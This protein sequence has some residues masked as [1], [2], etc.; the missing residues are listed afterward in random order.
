MVEP[1]DPIVDVF[2]AD[3]AVAVTQLLYFVVAFLAIWLAGRIVVVPLLSRAMSRRDLDRHAKVPLLKVTRISI[4]FVGIAVAFGFADYGNFLTSL[5][6]IAAAATLAIGFAMQDVIQN[7][8][9]GVFIFTD[10]PFRIGD[11]IEWGD[12]SGVVEDISLRVTRVRT[13][14][15]ELLTVPNSQLTDGVIKN[16]VAKDQLR[17]KFLFGIGYDED[18]DEATDIILEEAAAHEE[19]LDEPEPSVRLTELGD[20][21]VGLQ[22]RIWIANPKRSDF[23]RIRAEYVQAVKER[24]DEAEIEIPY[25]NRTLSGQVDVATTADMVAEAED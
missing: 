15:N 18:V 12:Y 21:S 17:L 24:F 1:L 2:G 16:P 22:S 14:D 20:S 6:T 19:I 4:V 7:F 10:R 13:F 11:W 3:L 9:A 25:P 23:V 8:V 5:A